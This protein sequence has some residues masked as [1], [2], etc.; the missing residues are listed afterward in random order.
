MTLCVLTQ[1]ID[2][3]GCD[4]LRAAGVEVALAPDT[5]LTS[6][7]PLLARAD[8]VITRNWGFGAAAMA[9]APRLRV[10]GSH[11][12]GVDRIDLVAASAR[13]IRVVNTPGAN[14][15]DVA[16]LALGLMLA[17][18]RLLPQ[19]DRALRAGDDGW[20]LRV[21]GLA[22]GGRCLGLW[23][24][25]QV[26]RALAPMAL[27]LGMD[28]VVCS[29]HADASELTAAGVTRVTDVA[30]FLAR[31]DILSLHGLPGPRPVLGA[32]E[33]AAL[34]PGA[35]VINTARGAL[36]D[37]AALADALQSGR[38]GGAALDVTVTEPLPPDHPFR[39]CPRL[40]LTPHIGSNTDRGM[41][42]TA[43]AVARAV[44]DALGGD[45]P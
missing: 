19:A 39:A 12:T 29:A 15:P 30:T 18:A 1:P 7:A 33:L 25:G 23:G 20:R 10:I 44:L 9:L 22:L 21:Q 38:L 45:A 14:A 35:L 2:P 17:A 24:W 28:V 13:G 41:T 42:S 6:L 32:A 3:I 34:R 36:I 27:G 11:G 31:V 5:A 4:L 26:A 16:E 40:V 43:R 8:A 37:E